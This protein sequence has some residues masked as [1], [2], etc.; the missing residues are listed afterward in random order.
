MTSRRML[1][2][3]AVLMVGFGSLAGCSSGSGGDARAAVK[4][5]AHQAAARS[6]SHHLTLDTSH[7]YGNKY[8]D[9]VLPV[10][11]GKYTS[12]GAKKGYIYACSQ[13]ASSL[14]SGNGGADTRG[15]WFTNNNT[16]YDV[17][18]KVPVEGSVS[19]PN[20]TH[21]IKTTST[22]RK[23]TSNG[24]PTSHTTGTFPIS[25]SDPAYS[26]DRN[27]NSITAQ[28]ISMSLTKSPKYGSPRCMGG[29]VGIM[30]TGVML[31]NA[32]DAEGR[33]AGAWETQDHCDAHPERTG[34]YHYH[35]LS[36]CI[37][38]RS[39]HHV[40][41]WAFDGFP[42]TGPYVHGS[43]NQLTTSN[44]DACHGITSKVKINGKSVT[45]Y[46][47]VMTQDY[48]Y[49]VSCFRAKPFTTGPVP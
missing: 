48:P 32:L 14:S 47:Y 1:V 9:G 34:V 37:T 16:E 27:P 43:S 23:I 15:P 11:D 13:Y 40:I 21:S 25:S 18:D 38:K 10:G 6:A 22:K 44:L 5:A 45:T 46:H 42:I 7:D 39:V 26:Y 8:S 35:T 36:S 4:P 12:S 17:N 20:A 41:G 24:L 2:G 28:S 33:D 30:T 3:A 29:E 31:F 19:W 49:S